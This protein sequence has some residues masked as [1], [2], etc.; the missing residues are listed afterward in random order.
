MPPGAACLLANGYALI[1]G[2]SMPWHKR[3]TSR[4]E[5]QDYKFFADVLMFNLGCGYFSTDQFVEAA[6]IRSDASKSGKYAG[7]GWVSRCGCYDWFQYGSHAA[8]MPIDFLEGDTVLAALSRMGA[9]WTGMWVPFGIDNQAFQKSAHK[10][11][12]TAK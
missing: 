9:C 10:G 6:E 8:R 7:G 11:R 4:A 1:A 2:L 3:R 12:S 5:R